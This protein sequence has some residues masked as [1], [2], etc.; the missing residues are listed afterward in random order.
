MFRERPDWQALLFHY[1][2]GVVVLWQLLEDLVMGQAKTYTGDLVAWRQLSPILVD[3][4]PPET[5]WALVGLEFCLLA[6][7][8]LRIQVRWV[9]IGLALI[10]LTDNLT[11]SL[12]HR[13]LMAI[14]IF[15]VGLEPVPRDAGVSGYRTK[16]LYWN[17][18]LVRWQVAV[19]YLFTAFHKSNPHFLSGQSLQNLFWMAQ[20]TWSPY[21][22]WLFE[23]LQNAAVCRVLAIMT[24]VTEISLAIGLQ[25]R[26]TVGWFLPVL[27]LLHLSFG[28]LM[29][30]IWIFTVQLILAA[31]V[32][33]PDRIETGA[34]YR[35]LV[36]GRSPWFG[37]LLW[38]GYVQQEAPESRAA[39]GELQLPGGRRE[40][41]LA[42][43]IHLMTLSPWTFVAA[44]TLWAIVRPGAPGREPGRPGA[45]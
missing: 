8:F 20:H 31:I 1:G 3:H 32:F 23:T 15:L 40:R 27:V 11:A 16:R 4:L 26:R 29:P 44:E 9:A 28:L 14:N 43:W 34:P 22:A 30:H 37:R 38:P 10:L 35:W 36:T 39:E 17:L 21:P 45:D 19:V 33:V 13:L 12:N 25:F 5:Y 18:D 2:A 24:V 6:L 7:Y 42:A 41:G